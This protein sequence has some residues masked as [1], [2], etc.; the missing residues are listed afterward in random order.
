MMDMKSIEILKV[1]PT[2][3]LLE[4]LD[5]IHEMDDDKKQIALEE[6]IYVLYEREVKKHE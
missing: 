2:D 6:L 5:E 3:L 4:M 1:F